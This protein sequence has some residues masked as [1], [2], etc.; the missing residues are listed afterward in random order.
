VTLLAA[1]GNNDGIVGAAD[2]VIWRKHASSPGFGAG[3]GVP[4]PSGPLILMSLIN[5]VLLARMRRGA[6]M[7]NSGSKF[8]G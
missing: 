6:K 2:Y 3:A 4:E 5:V 7:E 8:G 1:D